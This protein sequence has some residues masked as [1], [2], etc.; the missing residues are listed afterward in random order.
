LTRKALLLRV[1]IDRGTGGARSPIFPDGRF[2]YLPIPEDRRSRS[3]LTFATLPS[4]HGNTLAGFL[5]P[6]IAAQQP[7]LDP[8]F[9]AFTYGDAAL[10]KRRQL[11]R[12]RAGD[13]LVFYAGLEPWPRGD[14][15][16]LF[17]I[18]LLAV[19]EVYSL[20]ADRIA[21]DRALR[22]RFGKTAHFLLEPLDPELALVVGDERQSRL[23]GRALPLG[24][25]EDRLLRDLAS[26]GY[27]GSLRRAVGHWFEGPALAA[28]ED[29]IAHGPASFVGYA[30]RLFAVSPPD[31]RPANSYRGDL[32]I[33]DA[34]PQVGDW[35]CCREDGA[36]ALARINKRSE[37]GD[38][39]A[40]L[41]WRLQRHRYSGPDTDPRPAEPPLRRR[42]DAPVRL[43]DGVAL[44]H[45]CAH[46]VSAAI[47]C[48]GATIPRK[49]MSRAGA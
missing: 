28:I 42:R 38:G 30:T 18:G 48:V 26:L 34:R 12:L 39:R 9:E 43:L 10:R 46:L 40:S 37:Q 41:F 6:R 21:G 24:D 15:P 25:G 29:W 35:I 49:A 27:E 16:R 32:V 5:P 33:R 20:S 7:H 11:L 45:R 23:L 47:R 17:L 1:G 31:I 44:S 14:I 4:R 8:D 3:G 22:R 13:L 2:E 19:K 36:I